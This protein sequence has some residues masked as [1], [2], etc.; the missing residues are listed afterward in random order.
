M[1]LYTYFHLIN[2]GSPNVTIHHHRENLYNVAKK[3]RCQRRPVRA[4]VTYHKIYIYAKNYK[5]FLAMCAPA[6]TKY[7]RSIIT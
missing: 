1:T 4:R 7:S 2:G 3:P 6:S 5:I